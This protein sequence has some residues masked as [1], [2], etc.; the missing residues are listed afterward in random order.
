MQGSTKS[1]FTAP[2]EGWQRAAAVLAALLMAASLVFPLWKMEMVAPQYPEGLMLQVYPN[3]LAGGASEYVDHLAEINTLNHYIGMA[4]LHAEN[5][6][7]LRVLP[8]GIGIAAVLALLAATGRRAF[9]WAGL[10]VLGAIGTGGLG[11]A[12]YRLHQYGHNLDPTAPVKVDPFTPVFIGTNQL[13]NFT[14]TGSLGLGTYLL[15]AGALIGAV[16]LLAKIGR[17]RRT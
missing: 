6:P 5:F 1:L 9:L 12:L 13:A 15:L 4:E 8:I 11:S 10:A 17:A 16:A 14:T 2:F 7:E 3:R